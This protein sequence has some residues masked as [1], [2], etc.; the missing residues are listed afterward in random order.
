MSLSILMKKHSTI[1]C[2]YFDIE[3]IQHNLIKSIVIHLKLR[4]LT[5]KML[6]SDL[7]IHEVSLVFS[8]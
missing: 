3:T 2:C 5:W 1:V 8:L 7:F 6:I 4:N